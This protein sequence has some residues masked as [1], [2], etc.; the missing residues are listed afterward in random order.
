[1]NVEAIYHLIEKSTASGRGVSYWEVAQ[2]CG[3]KRYLSDLHQQLVREGETNVEEKRLGTYVHGLIHHWYK[4]SFPDDVVIDVSDTQPQPWADAVK[5]FNFMRSYFP[6][7][8]WGDYVDSELKLPIDEAHRAAIREYF[9][10]DEITG[11]IDWLAELE[12]KHI[13]NYREK[14]LE[15]DLPGPGLY[16]LD[17]KTGGARKGPDAARGA[18]LESIQSK[19][20]PLLA[21]LGG[22]NVR[23]VIFVYFVN[24]TVMRRYDEGKNKGA[25]IQ[26]FYAPHNEVRDMQARAA[27]NFAK[28]QRDSRT[29]NPY[30]CT[31]YTG[32]SCVFKNKGICDGLE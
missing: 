1:M 13:L 26:A 23:G 19:N 15:L 30:A 24:H 5:I 17:W 4:G 6:K 20:Y 7:D 25:S 12:E 16:I 31:T 3:E 14:E 28:T 2:N 27:V 32:Q 21:R 10:H 8:F 22:L 11:Q 18:F 29:K 9:G